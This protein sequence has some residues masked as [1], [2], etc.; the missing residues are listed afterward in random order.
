M[1]IGISCY[2][3][4]VICSM[5]ETLKPQYWRPRIESGGRRSSE[6]GERSTYKSGSNIG[7]GHLIEM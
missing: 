1:Q 6:G 5:E 2:W 4:M 7:L 3:R